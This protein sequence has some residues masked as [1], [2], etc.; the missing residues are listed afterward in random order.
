[1]GLIYEFKNPIYE[2]QYIIEI[3]YIK[4]LPTESV[5]DFDQ[6]FKNFMAK[7]IF[8][9]SD[10]QHKEWFIATMLPHICIP[11]M[12]HKIVSQ[13]KALE[14]VMKLEASQVGETGA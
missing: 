9:M 14:L 5:W 7:V 2:S 3:K 10:V 11:L 1:M 12:Q 8:Q 13:I 6:R 4:Q